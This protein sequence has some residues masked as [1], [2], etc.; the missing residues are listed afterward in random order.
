VPSSST[1]AGVDAIA[2]ETRA[3]LR[4]CIGSP[5]VRSNNLDVFDLPLTVGTLVLDPD[6]GQMDVPIYDRQIV[7]SG[8]L[9]NLAIDRI[10]IPLSSATLAV[11]VLKKSLVVPLELVVQNHPPHNAASTP[12]AVGGVQIG[13]VELS[14]MGQFAGSRCLRELRHPLVRVA[15]PVTLDGSSDR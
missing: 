9:C 3:A 11:E 13:P 12:Q 8:P 10:C 1:D 15:A 14:V 2:G 6:V 5:I 4:S 7:A